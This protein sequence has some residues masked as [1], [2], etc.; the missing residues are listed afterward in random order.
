MGLLQLDVMPT[1]PVSDVSSSPESESTDNS[2]SNAHSLSE[3]INDW[4]RE[5]ES[6]NVQLKDKI[7]SIQML[8]SQLRDKDSEIYEVR[9]R[10]KSIEIDRDKNWQMVSSKK[11]CVK[12]QTSR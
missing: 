9:T 5:L 2:L 1:E 4:K 12:I 3:V 8:E 11:Y 7:S 6:K 10:C